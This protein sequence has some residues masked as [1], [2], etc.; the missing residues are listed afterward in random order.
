[1]GALV[2]ISEVSPARP[3]PGAI[4]GGFLDRPRSGALL[5]AQIVDVSGW[6]VGAEREAV[7][8]EFSTRGEAIWRA[9]LRAA[10]PD[11][12]EVF[13][14]RPRALSAGFETTIDLVGTP[15]EFELDVVVVLAGGRRAPLATVRGRHRWRR[16][17]RPDFAEL[18]SVAIAR[19][20]RTDGLAGA[21][22]SVL[23]Q[24]CPRGEGGGV[25]GH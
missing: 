10:R 2:E 22:E 4:H 23:A 18:V 15:P 21:I 16:Q 19:R 20:D 8:V 13:P 1:M 17:S 11:L 5:D 9:P 25:D 7:A 6:A 3:L 12:A 14:Q 24:A